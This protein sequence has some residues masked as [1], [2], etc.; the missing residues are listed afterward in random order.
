[1]LLVFV[2]FSQ[3]PPGEGGAPLYSY[4]GAQ[5]FRKFGQ[6]FRKSGHFFRKPTQLH[7]LYMSRFFTSRALSSMN[8]RR[9]STSSPINV[10]KISLVST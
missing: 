7:W 5:Y 6:Y 9:F 3:I 4:P 1:M 8:L 2:D 10:V